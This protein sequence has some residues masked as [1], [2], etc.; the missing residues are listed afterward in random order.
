M[1]V[2][3]SPLVGASDATSNGRIGPEDRRRSLSA[4]LDDPWFPA[5]IYTSLVKGEGE[6][7]FALI[8]SRR[9]GD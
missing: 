6:D 3:I 8:W 2:S 9:A 5:P 4:K 7:S 1:V